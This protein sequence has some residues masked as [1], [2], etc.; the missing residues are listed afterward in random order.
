MD[1]KEPLT[2]LNKCFGSQ[3]TMDFAI[4]SGF[5]QE[6]HN[7]TFGPYFDLRAVRTCSAS[8]QVGR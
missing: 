1:T 8:T 6:G 7:Y 5:E 2:L 4:P 3:N